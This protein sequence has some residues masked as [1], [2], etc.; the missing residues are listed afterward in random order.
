MRRCRS[1]SEAKSPKRVDSSTLSSV[2]VVV[3]IVAPTSESIR[4][5]GYIMGDSVK[6]LSHIVHK[7]GKHLLVVV[8]GAT[9]LIAL[10]VG[11]FVDTDCVVVFVRSLIVSSCTVFPQI[12]SPFY[13]P[14]FC[15]R[16]DLSFSCHSKKSR[17]RSLPQNVNYLSISLLYP[18]L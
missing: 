4:L 7:V 12:A 16:F 15:R 9:L 3:I 10:F 5:F 11:S 14:C 6:C 18:P 2:S 8:M 1:S 17:T 13:A